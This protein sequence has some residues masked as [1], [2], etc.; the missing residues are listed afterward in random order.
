MVH[1]GYEPSAVSATFGTWRGFWATAKVALFGPLEDQPL[2]VT[3]TRVPGTPPAITLRQT[4]DGR[5]ELPV[6]K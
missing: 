5:I 3:T 6:V 1:S 4:S 2:R